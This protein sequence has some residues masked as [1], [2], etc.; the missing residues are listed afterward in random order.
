MPRVH[1]AADW[2]AAMTAMRGGQ[3]FCHNIH[4]RNVGRRRK[5]RRGVGQ[6]VAKPVIR[7]GAQRDVAID[8]DVMVKRPAEFLRTFPVQG[9][10]D[11]GQWHRG[12]YQ[13]EDPIIE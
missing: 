7:P 11:I 5:R 4:R 8:S 9:I 2:A 10:F 3:T 6:V 13:P 12:R 1:R